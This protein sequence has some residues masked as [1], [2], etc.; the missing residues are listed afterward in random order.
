MLKFVLLS[1]AAATALGSKFVMPWMCLERCGGNKSTI[2]SALD[3]FR[4]HSTVLTAVAFEVRAGARHYHG[5]LPTLGFLQKYNLGPNST[6]VRNSLTDPSQAL[7]RMRLD[8]FPMVSSFP[9]PEDFM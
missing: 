4:V 5:L 2:K 9:Y 1:A 6:L 7:Q 3:E 8:T